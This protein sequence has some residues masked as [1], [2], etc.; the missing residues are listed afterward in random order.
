MEQRI[1][2]TTLTLRKKPAT[3][4][5]DT[6]PPMS[7]VEPNPL[8]DI[9]DFTYELIPA[10]ESNDIDDDYSFYSD[11]KKVRGDKR[12]QRNIPTRKEARWQ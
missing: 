5:D 6:S 12:T 9:P 3:T 1:K 2:K 10:L 11:R 7:I 8:A 4:P